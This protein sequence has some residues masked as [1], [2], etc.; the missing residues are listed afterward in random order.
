MLG[1]LVRDLFSKAPLC[2]IGNEAERKAWLRLGVNRH[3][4]KIITLQRAMTQ[5]HEEALNPR[6]ACHTVPTAAK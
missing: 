1:C 2:S 5:P 4:T 3:C 6:L